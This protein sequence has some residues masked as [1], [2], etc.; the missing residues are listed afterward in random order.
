MRKPENLGLICDHVNMLYF[1]VYRHVRDWLYY[2]V[3]DE[4][5]K[6]WDVVLCRL[7]DTSELLDEHAAW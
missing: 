4:G 2:N 1:S 5:T 6:V 7:V 3:I